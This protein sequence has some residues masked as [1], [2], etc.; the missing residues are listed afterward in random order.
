LYDD[1]ALQTFLLLKRLLW[2]GHI[3]RMDD[4]C[5]LKKSNGRMFQRKKAHGIA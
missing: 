3:V 1:V 5:I 2:A 4:F